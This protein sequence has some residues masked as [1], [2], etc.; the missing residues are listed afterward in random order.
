[1]WTTTITLNFVAVFAGIPNVLKPRFE[2]QMSTAEQRELRL[3]PSRLQVPKLLRRDASGAG[4]ARPLHGTNNTVTPYVSQEGGR[5]GPES[6]VP[7][8]L[9]GIH[10]LLMLGRYGLMMRG[11][12]NSNASEP[13]NALLDVQAGADALASMLHLVHPVARCREAIAKAKSFVAKANASLS[14]L[15]LCD[16]DFDVVFANMNV[17]NETAKKARHPKVLFADQLGVC[18][19][20]LWPRACSFWASLHAMSVR[21]DMLGKGKA[22]LMAVTRIM[23][24][25]AL[26]CGGCQRHF[27]LLMQPLIP[28]SINDKRNHVDS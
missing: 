21:A 16:A 2:A 23:A 8:D 24:G 20:S 27:I 9:W 1:M 4:L 10:D 25:G 19:T 13:S 11:P 12:H 6:I 18:K 28:A 26:F 14:C 5:V 3:S 15:G 22:Y 7:K 17:N